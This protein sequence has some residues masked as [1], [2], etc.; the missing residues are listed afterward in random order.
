MFSRKRLGL[1]TRLTWR[2][3][4]TSRKARRVTVKKERRVTVKK[5]RRVK[6]MI[7]QTKLLRKRMTMMMKH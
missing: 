7:T 6:T 2:V 5:E 3:H 1:I 4:Q